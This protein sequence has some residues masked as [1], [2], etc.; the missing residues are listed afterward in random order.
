M[1]A[2]A[3]AQNATAIGGTLAY[4]TSGK[5]ASDYYLTVGW[6]DL[7]KDLVIPLPNI[8]SGEVLGRGGAN[9][10]ITCS[11][12][13]QLSTCQ[14]PLTLAISKVL[15]PHVLAIKMPKAGFFQTR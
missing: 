9:I 2:H 15:D 13:S 12:G 7:T 5:A 3:V 10:R 1:G 8:S 6:P 4:M 11:A 14:L